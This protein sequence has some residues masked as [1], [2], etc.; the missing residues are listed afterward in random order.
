[1]VALLQNHWPEAKRVSLSEVGRGDGLGQL[2]GECD[3]LVFVGAMGICVRTIAPLL[4]HKHTDPAVVCVD[5]VGKWAIPVVSGHVGGANA[6]A[7]EIARVIGAL[8]VVTTQSDQQGLWALDTLG[9]Q[10]GWGE[11]CVGA[12]FNGCISRFVNGEPTAL[13]LEHEDEATHYLEDTLPLHVTLCRSI[14]EVQSGCYALTIAVTPFIH[15]QLTMPVLYFRP[16]VLHLGVGCRR[17]CAVEGVLQ[18]VDDCLVRHGISP[19]CVDRVASVELKRNEP[20]L[21]ALCEHYGVGL[22]IFSPEELQGI[23]VPNPSLRVEEVVGVPS[24]S[25]AAAMRSAATRRLLIDKQKGSCSPGNEYTLAVAAAE[26]QG[27]RGGHVAIVG[28]GPGAVDL[29][30]VRGKRLLSRADMVLYA[31][32]LVR[33][34][35]LQYTRGGT[36]LHSSDGY[37]LEQQ[38]ALIKRVYNR[39]GLVVR[40]HTGDPSIY[41]AIGEQMALFDREGISYSITPGV[42][43]FQAAAAVLKTQYTIPGDTQTVI[44]TRASGRTAVLERERLSELARSRSTMCIFLS[45][46]L[47][48][49]VE[50]DL[51]TH[52]PPSTPVAICHAVTWPQEQVAICTL[53]E[54]TSEMKRLGFT[55]H[56]LIVVGQAVGNRAG[57]SFLYSQENNSK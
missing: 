49:Q 11:E 21:K 40:L 9:G 38:L 41:G 43:S 54:L 51:L 16:R 39:G 2:F 3:L 6:Y 17:D 5:S 52:Y 31:G 15:S 34:E 25:E 48:E 7:R 13:L 19:R 56:T 1:M 33:E 53:R 28:A 22:S 47:V 14:E 23:D 55:Q 24:V 50:S 35:I 57:R 29:I 37:S 30:T 18:Q 44:L 26:E 46:S 20:L 32:S 42:S 45:A 4:V 36:A 12:S 27:V 8:P 10:F